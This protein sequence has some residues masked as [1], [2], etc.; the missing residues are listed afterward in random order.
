MPDITFMH[1]DGS[2]QGFEAPIGVSLMP[3]FQQ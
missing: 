1:A 2:E 3:E